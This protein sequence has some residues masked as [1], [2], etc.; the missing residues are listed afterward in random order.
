MISVVKTFRAKSFLIK[1]SDKFSRLTHRSP[2]LERD[3]KTESARRHP[4][5]SQDHLAEFVCTGWVG[6]NRPA[7]GSQKLGVVLGCKRVNSACSL[8]EITRLLLKAVL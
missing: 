5:P 2:R 4:A 1:S 3:V 6:E 7:A 8:P